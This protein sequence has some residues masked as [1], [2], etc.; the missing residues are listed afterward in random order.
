MCH[1]L[2]NTKQN[3]ISDQKKKH[4]LNTAAKLFAEAETNRSKLGWKGKHTRKQIKSENK[5]PHNLYEENVLAQ[6]DFRKEKEI[7]EIT[8]MIN[9]SKVW[10]K[11][12]NDTNKLYKG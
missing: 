12:K 11:K 2:H 1:K 3:K 10:I 7:S 4:D 5:Q 6:L 9:K 8:Y